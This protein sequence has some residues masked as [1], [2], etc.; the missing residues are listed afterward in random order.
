MELTLFLKTANLN[1]RASIAK[2]PSTPVDILVQLSQDE[3]WMVRQGVAGHRNTPAEALDRLSHCLIEDQADG[4]LERVASNHNTPAEAL[5]R[6]SQ[7]ENEQ[8]RYYVVW[9][10][11][12]PIDTLVQLSQDKSEF[13]RRKVA[14]NPRTPID[15][16][17]RLSQDKSEKVRKEV[18]E[19]PNWSDPKNQEKIEDAR[20]LIDLG[21]A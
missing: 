19:N 8:V 14:R 10:P 3:D 16:L 20:Y 9:N 21:M 2:D 6:L 15:T 13:V 1:T 17:V 5:V 11:N 7:D 12:T 4:T 18:T